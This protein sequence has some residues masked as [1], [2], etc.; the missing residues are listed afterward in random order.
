MYLVKVFLHVGAIDHNTARLVL[1]DHPGSVEVG[2]HCCL[3]CSHLC[4]E[5]SGDLQ[6][7]SLAPCEY[8]MKLIV[9][10]AKLAFDSMSIFN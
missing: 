3:A 7:P 2:T 4:L 9:S 1:P 8:S 5:I 10:E 6:T